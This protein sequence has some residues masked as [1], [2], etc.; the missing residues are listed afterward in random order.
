MNFLIKNGFYVSDPF[1]LDRK[2]KVWTKK[3][4]DLKC[5]NTYISWQK[6][7]GFHI[8]ANQITFQDTIS[9]ELK[10]LKEKDGLMNL[11]NGLIIEQKSITPLCPE[12]FTL[13]NLLYDVSQLFAVGLKDSDKR[14]PFTDIVL[15]DIIIYQ[16]RLDTTQI[17]N[18]N[19]N[20]HYGSEQIV[21]KVIS[22]FYKRED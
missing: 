3:P 1:N 6:S 15:R 10:D 18:L 19:K 2:F 7:Y 22:D 20:G 17:K 8:I 14:E 21:M 4:K 13:V 9:F 5:I 16:D 11:V 12:S